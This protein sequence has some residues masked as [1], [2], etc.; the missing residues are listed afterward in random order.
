MLWPFV[1]GCCESTWAPCCCQTHNLLWRCCEYRPKQTFKATETDNTALYTIKRIGNEHA[2]LSCAPPNWYKATLC[3][4]KVY[5]GIELHCEHWFACSLSDIKILLHGA[6]RRS[7]V[8]YSLRG[9]QCRSMV[10]YSLRGA[11]CR[12][13]VLYS[14]HGAQCRSMVLYSLR[15]AQCRSMVLYSLRGAQCKSMVLYSLGGAQRAPHKPTVHHNP[16]SSCQRS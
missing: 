15:G 7:M 9:A 8:L 1:R 16:L 13:M 11:Q 3:T 14:L 12:S 6:Q 5:I 10:L 2:K 4:T